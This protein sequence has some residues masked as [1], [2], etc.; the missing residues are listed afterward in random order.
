MRLT[1]GMRVLGVLL[2]LVLAGG[3][4]A[5]A[6]SAASLAIEPVLELYRQEVICQEAAGVPEAATPEDR[7]ADGAAATPSGDAKVE[8]A[9]TPVP[10]LWPG[11][12][13]TPI[14]DDA[15]SG[16]PVVGDEAGTP[17]P[18]GSPAT[19][20]GHAVEANVEGF[21]CQ[22]VPGGGT[23]EIGID[24]DGDGVLDPDEVLGTDLDNDGTITEDEFDAEAQWP[25]EVAPA[26]VGAE[27]ALA[28][29]NVLDAN[30]KGYLRED[31]DDDG[32]F[33]IGIDIDASGTLDE[34]E[35][36]GSDLNNDEA[37]TEDELGA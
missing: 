34:N 8:L 11:V 30:D 19:D 23:L 24:E 28:D 33:E 4:H 1:C 7:I 2:P 5:A 20:E 25:A 31:T 6:N 10:D 27:E 9:G 3:A 26:E 12:A 36:V 14:L 16:T 35:V 18:V 17:V 32:T 37:L 29:D 15:L 13:S 22:D 21:V